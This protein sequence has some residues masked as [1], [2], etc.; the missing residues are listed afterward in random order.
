MRPPIAWMVP[1]LLTDGATNAARPALVTVMPR[2]GWP[3]TG[4]AAFETLPV[5]AAVIAKLPP[6]MNC[7]SLTLPVEAM[8]P[9]TLTLALAPNR[10]PFGLRIITWPLAFRTPSMFA[11]GPTRLSAIE[12]VPGWRNVTEAPLP[13]LKVLQLMIARSA[14]WL[15]VTAEPTVLIV[16]FVALP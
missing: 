15:T 14:L 16:A 5:V 9:P 3:V 13:M 7:V 2:S 1:E 4:F 10:T 8:R 11:A 12:L 6:F